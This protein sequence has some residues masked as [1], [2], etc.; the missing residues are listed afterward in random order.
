MYC[1]Q[2]LPLLAGI[3]FPNEKANNFLCSSDRKTK[4]DCICCLIYCC[5]EHY[6]QTTSINKRKFNSKMAPQLG[7]ISESST[8]D[9]FSLISFPNIP[10]STFSSFYTAFLDVPQSTSS[11]SPARGYMF[12]M[13]EH[14]QSNT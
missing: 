10:H 14:S 12:Q 6:S 4:K 5:Q 2:S 9:H 1:L 8:A 11:Q 7:K 3:F 13:T